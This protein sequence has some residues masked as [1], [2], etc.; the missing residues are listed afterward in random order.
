MKLLFTVVAITGTT[1]L[2][3]GNVKARPQIYMTSY[4]HGNTHQKCMTQAKTVLQENGFGNFVE[5]QYLEERMS[6]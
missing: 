2:S 6:V 1:L 5:R 4:S 3:A